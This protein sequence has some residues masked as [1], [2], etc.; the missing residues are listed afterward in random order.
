MKNIPFS[1]AVVL[2]CFYLCC[3]GMLHPA[4]AAL[5]PSANAPSTSATEP[6]TRGIPLACYLEVARRY[7]DP[8]TRSLALLDV[9]REYARSNQPRQAPAILQESIATAKTLENASSR[10][11]ILAE[12]AAR[13]ETLQDL[14]TSDREVLQATLVEGAAAARAASDPVQKAFALAKVGSLQVGDRREAD[15]LLAESIAAAN[16]VEDAY[17]KTRLLVAIADGYVDTQHGD[18]AANL[19]G[20]AAPLAETIEDVAARSRALVEVARGYARGGRES[21]SVRALQQAVGGYEQAVRDRKMPEDPGFEYRALAYIARAYAEANQ[22]DRAFAVIR[23]IQSPV[24]LLAALLD[25]ADRL[26]ARGEAEKGLQVLDLGGKLVGGNEVSLDRALAMTLLGDAYIKLDR[27][28]RAIPVLNGALQVVGLL[29]NSPEKANILAELAIAYA[30]AGDKRQATR[31]LTQ[32]T[33][34]P[35]TPNPDPAR[36][37]FLGDA[38]AAYSLLGKYD[39]AREVAQNLRDSAERDRLLELLACVQREIG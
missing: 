34:M 27:P 13:Y 7:V 21:D 24:D 11:Y 22:F 35:A 30:E 14:S 33:S 6:T 17:L 18:R 37:Q 39:K 32:G 23:N 10:A 26:A 2:A 31:A 1:I 4:I 16:G 12:A 38:V 29:P 20:R 19:L 3:V 5:S 8:G 9:A 28:D 15:A 36:E 25:V